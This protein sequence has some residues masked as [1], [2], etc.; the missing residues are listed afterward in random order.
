MNS[1]LSETEFASKSLI[2]I[3]FTEEQNFKK[4]SE[5]FEN[6][7]RRFDFLYKDY[8]TAE[9]M[10]DFDDLLVLHKF[11]QTA[12]FY[13]ENEIDTKKTELNTLKQ[14]I[15]TKRNS[16]NALAMSLLQIA[17]QG[18]S[19]V[20]GSLTNCSDGRSI[21]NETLKNVIWQGRNQSIHFEENNPRPETLKCF[22]NLKKDFGS[23]F[24]L[25]EKPI[26]NKAKEIIDLLGWTNYESFKED[27]IALLG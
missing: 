5:N 27:M 26:E 4:L 11:N 8:T 10:D 22:E 24:N 17:K 21:G 13:Q 18:I 7:K 9:Q 19:T 2:E 6:L 15:Q 1:Y 20:H 25:S 3:I 14:S 23:A 16:I 12:R